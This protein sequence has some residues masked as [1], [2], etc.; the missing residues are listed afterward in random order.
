MGLEEMRGDASDR[1]LFGFFTV[2]VFGWS[3]VF[4]LE[5]AKAFGRKEFGAWYKPWHGELHTDPLCLYFHDV[6]DGLIH[7]PN[8]SVAVVLAAYG[9]AGRAVGDISIPG[10]EIPKKHRGQKLD[11]LD[12]RHLCTLFVTYLDDLV[13]SATPLIVE[14]QNRA[15]A[16]GKVAKAGRPTP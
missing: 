6:R 5:H 4:N 8:P 16:S 12:I 3:I 7:N 13:N 15:D 2:A 14:F 10:K 1:A 9:T 11:D